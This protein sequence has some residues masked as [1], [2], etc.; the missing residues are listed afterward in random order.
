L[1]A[2]ADLPDFGGQDPASL[3]NFP[4]RIAENLCQ[5]VKRWALSKAP[6]RH[7]E[8]R[9]QH[10]FP[11]YL[12][13][14]CAVHGYADCG[15]ARG[16]W[17]TGT[18]RMT[19]LLMAIAMAI[20]LAACTARPGPAP[21]LAARYCYRT[22]AEVDCHARALPGEATRELGFFDQAAVR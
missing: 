21:D 11:A 20:L 4:S 2:P 19:R 10:R 15:F 14:F 3:A 18:D 7:L 9:A 12:L 17:L 8:S 1:P 22:L 6:W 16:T 5:F 13:A